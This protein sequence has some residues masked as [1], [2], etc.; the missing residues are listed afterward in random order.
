MIYLQA[1]GAV[2]LSGVVMLWF[3]SYQERDIVRIMSD[4][5]SLNNW[6]FA[7]G[8]AFGLITLGV[9]LSCL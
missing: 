9:L 6:K 5:E 2:L 1:L 3:T 4:T 8:A 7:K